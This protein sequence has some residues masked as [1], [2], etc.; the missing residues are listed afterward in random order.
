MRQ[1]PKRILN[2]ITEEIQELLKKPISLIVLILDI[3]SGV[4]I[5][6]S[7][8]LGKMDIHWIILPVA[9]LIGIVLW[10]YIRLKIEISNFKE[11]FNINE[12][13]LSAFTYIMNAKKRTAFNDFDVRDV[14]IEYEFR[15]DNGPANAFMQT[16]TWNFLVQN[17]SQKPITRMGMMVAK[18]VFSN[19]SNID[20]YA[21]DNQTKRKLHIVKGKKY[22][23]QR[24]IEIIF[25]GEGLAASKSLEFKVIMRWEQAYQMLGPETIIVDPLN[26]SPNT[27]H[28]NT[29]IKTNSAFLE[30]ARVTY[31]AVK[32]GSLTDS[33]E[34]YNT[35][36][37]RAGQYEYNC[38]HDF[39]PDMN[40]LYL[41]KIVS[42]RDSE[43]QPHRRERIL[44]GSAT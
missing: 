43:N 4:G 41:I 37:L 8:D 30:N 26:Y 31:V 14:D 1:L 17:N 22:A 24:Y 6:I 27:H 32:R 38:Q 9:I 11:I 28:I 34:E 5:F 33:D 21:I 7:S 29:T 25:D 15:H 20:F 36:I 42:E 39:V 13:L 16:F 19:H 35:S 2:M 10:K 44:V 12:S 18:T 23:N 3:I 40:K